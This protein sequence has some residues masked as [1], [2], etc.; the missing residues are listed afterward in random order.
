M[1]KVKLTQDQADAIESIKRFW[2][3]E[4]DEDEK[5][6]NIEHL[7]KKKI[8]HPKWFVEEDAPIQDM[9]LLDF[10]DSL[11]FGYEV[12]SEYKEGDWIAHK[13]INGIVVGKVTKVF[14]NEKQVK[15]D[16]INSAGDESYF[17]LMD[18][19]HATPLE[20]AEEKE[21]RWWNKHGRDVW[22]LRKGDVIGI[23]IKTITINEVREDGYIA[24]FDGLGSDRIYSIDSL[25][26]GGYKIICFAEDR[27]DV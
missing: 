27:K 2:V 17:M 8:K 7:I 15:T 6:S 5:T 11:R 21:R 24:Y 13:S 16:I 4:E 9:S 26:S 25:K 14:K 10:I 20:I 22:E 19:R 18:I 3:S 12:V 23:N 1:E